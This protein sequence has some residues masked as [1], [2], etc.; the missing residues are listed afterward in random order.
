M[1][2][3]EDGGMASFGGHYGQGDGPAPADIL[4]RTTEVPLAGVGIHAAR[5]PRHRAGVS[6]RGG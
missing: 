6:A 4:R 2:G 1:A 5:D 3:G